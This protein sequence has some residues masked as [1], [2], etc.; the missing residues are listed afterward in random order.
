MKLVTDRLVVRELNEQ[1]AE[2]VLA[3][4][5]SKGFKENIGDRNVRTI[6]EA[7]DK[8]NNFYT[9]EYPTYGLFAVTLADTDIPVGTVSY[10]KRDYLE[11]DDIGYAFLPEFWGAGYAFEATKAVMDYKLSQGIKDIWG[12]VNSDNKPSIKLLEKLGFQ[13]T[14][15]VVMEGEE[16]P[17]LK[18]E[19]SADVQ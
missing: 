13:T 11:H 19:Y 8:I 2:F 16:E 6:A 5:N 17:I 4:L 10:L 18:M 1:D 12:V 7:Q 14:G 15:M 3:L 9:S